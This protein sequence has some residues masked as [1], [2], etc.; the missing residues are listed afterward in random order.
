MKKAWEFVK[1]ICQLVKE[2]FLHFWRKIDWREISAWTTMILIIIVIVGGILVAI[3]SLI[4][5][6]AVPEVGVNLSTAHNYTDNTTVEFKVNGKKIPEVSIVQVWGEFKI[7]V[8]DVLSNQEVDNFNIES[9]IKDKSFITY[10]YDGRIGQLFIQINYV[11]G[12][13]RQVLV[14]TIK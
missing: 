7:S 3:L 11:D 4:D 14:N 6:F 9:L 2:K 5:Y 12:S 8:V 1:R 10:G 13:F